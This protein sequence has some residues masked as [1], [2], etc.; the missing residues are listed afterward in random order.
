MKITRFLSGYHEDNKV[1][2]QVIMK[3]T[4]FLSGYHEDNKVFIRLS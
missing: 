4:R 3:I 2:Y 1:F